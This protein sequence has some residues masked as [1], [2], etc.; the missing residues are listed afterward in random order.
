MLSIIW[1]R[2]GLRAPRTPNR[3]KPTTA[4]GHEKTRI[5]SHT[6]PRGHYTKRENLTQSRLR[7]ISPI[8]YVGEGREGAKRRGSLGLR[9]T[10]SRVSWRRRAEKIERGYE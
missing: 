6:E 2:R 9:E 4:N 7:P 10:E 5:K 1:V 8:N 3:P